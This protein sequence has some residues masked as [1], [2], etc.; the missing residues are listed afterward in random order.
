LLDFD[1]LD[2]IT[3]DITPSRKHAPFCG[4]DGEGGEIN[5]R[6]EY[7]LL[8]AGE[9]VLETGKPLTTGDCFHFLAGLPKG[10]VYVAF[11]FNYDVTMMLRGLPP[12]R[13]KRILHPELRR[14]T[15]CSQAYPV[16]IGAYQVDYIPHKEFRVR[17]R[18]QP[19]TIIHDTGSFFQEAFAKLKEDGTVTGALDKWLGDEPDLTDTIYNIALGKAQ[20]DSFT[21]MTDYERV[22]N[23]R[24]VI[25]LA[26]M[27]EK[28][29][30]MCDRLNL[31]PAKW[32]GPGHLVTAFF[33]R[34]RFPKK[35]DLLVFQ[36]VEFYDF[37]RMAFYGGRFEDCIYG[38]IPG[39]IYQYDKNSAYASIY[40]DL[41][42]MIHTKWTKTSVLPADGIYVADVEF[43]HPPG[44][45][46][47]TLPIRTD[48]GTL[49]FPRTGRGVYWCYEIEAA[50]QVGCEIRLAGLCY[51]AVQ[52]CD[53]SLFDIVHE[54]YAERR[55]LG[56][57]TQG[58][59]LKL[60]LATIY[61]KFAQSVGCAPYANPVYA[62]MI[63]SSCRAELA[64]ASLQDG[65]NGDDVIMLATDG[66]FTREPRDLPLSE[67]IGDWDLKV[68]DAM[69][70]IQ[71]G[72][73]FL[74]PKDGEDKLRTRGINAS[75]LAEYEIDFRSVWARW[76]DNPD[77]R[78]PPE[79]CIPLHMFTGIRLAVARNKPETAGD[80]VDVAKRIKFDW[81][82]KRRPL[83]ISDGMLLTIPTEG[84]RALRSIPYN[85]H[86][87]M[88][89]SLERA[90]FDDQPEWGDE[91]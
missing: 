27:M 61:G 34:E 71:S 4:V 18:G 69:L 21:A 16:D 30:D 32:Q 52:Q 35:K 57:S 58:R 53:C 9:H 23:E 11:F 91:L 14:K 87:H 2:C 74:P 10:R 39:P 65:R 17:K 15:L 6:H 81:E 48:K 77:Y 90:V 41:P 8:R 26:R 24:E 28:Y 84:S 49:I 43:H 29:R 82:S 55:R 80:W 75:K 46:V 20:R 50:R 19:W 3:A 12:E 7:L 63:T 83:K 67:R 68:H 86:S 76:I 37:I 47:N 51:R 56:S 66:I 89:R 59:P 5:G 78:Y 72:V 31:H 60:L 54:L 36:D 85:P 79:V 40:D 73:Y 70:S 1:T 62:G 25:L 44:Y 13:L 64:T 22:Y 88:E 42:C 38:D 45:R 33:R